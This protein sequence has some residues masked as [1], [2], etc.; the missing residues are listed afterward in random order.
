[1]NNVMLRGAGTE[2]KGVRGGKRQMVYELKQRVW[3]SRGGR[4]EMFTPQVAPRVPG[5]SRSP[6]VKL[7]SKEAANGSGRIRHVPAHPWYPNN[8]ISGSQEEGG[9]SERQGGA[10]SR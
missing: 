6:L 2:V 5:T 9:V 7:T 3:P 10:Q 1:M 8:V 4:R